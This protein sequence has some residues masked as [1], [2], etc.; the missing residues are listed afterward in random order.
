MTR[1]ACKIVA[2]SAALVRLREERVLL[3]RA[4]RRTLPWLAAAQLDRPAAFHQL[5]D[6][7]P[8]HRPGAFDAM[9]VLIADASRH[10]SIFLELHFPPEARRRGD[11]VMTDVVG[12]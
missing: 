7:Q 4:V 8:N 9:P 5:G 6:L 12:L 11:G 2:T 10:L 3:G 1:H